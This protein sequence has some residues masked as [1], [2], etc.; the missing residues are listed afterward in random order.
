MYY[1]SSLVSIDY[2]VYYLVG[3]SG[4]NRGAGA[5]QSEMVLYKHD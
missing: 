5:I 1:H 2:S 3:I 4:K